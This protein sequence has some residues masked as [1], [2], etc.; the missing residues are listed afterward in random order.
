MS[1]LPKPTSAPRSAIAMPHSAWDQIVN[2]LDQQG[3]RQH[4]QQGDAQPKRESRIRYTKIISCVMRLKQDGSPPAVYK[5]TTR[6]FSSGGL[7]FFFNQY[8]HAGT[9]CHFAVVDRHGVGRILEGQVR[10]CRHV[11]SNVH[12]CGV[13]FSIPM[14]PTDFVEVEPTVDTDEPTPPD[15]A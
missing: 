11:S 15:A 6:N 14:D 10:W 3:Q 13:Q 7:G 1:A 8:L 4:R 9:V 2:R 5:V 12:E